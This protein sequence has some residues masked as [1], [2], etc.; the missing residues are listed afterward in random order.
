[1]RRPSRDPSCMHCMAGRVCG[2]LDLVRR[3]GLSESL[4]CLARLADSASRIAWVEF[5]M[6]IK[7]LDLR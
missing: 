3:A 7:D 6:L 1:M 2:S 5:N 4:V